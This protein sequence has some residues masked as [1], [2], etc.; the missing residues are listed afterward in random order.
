MREGTLRWEEPEWRESGID[1]DLVA[2]AEAHGVA[3][4]YEDWHRERRDVAAASVIGVLGLLGVDASTPEAVA[5]ELAAVREA[6]RLKRL[7]GTVVVRSGSAK[8][9]PG[10][11]HDRAGGRHRAGR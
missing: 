6:R 2:L 9:L 3:T 4:W 10:P 1:A 7:P 11:G 8:A 5:A